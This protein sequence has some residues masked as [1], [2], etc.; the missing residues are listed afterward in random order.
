MISFAGL[1]ALVFVGLFAYLVYLVH[2]AV[3]L[4]RHL[5]YSDYNTYK[6]AV[7]SSKKVY[8][9]NRDSKIES[10]HSVKGDRTKMTIKK[11]SGISKTD[12]A[13]VDLAHADPESVMNSIDEYGRPR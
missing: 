13:L 3:D 10:I 2:E 8:K 4:Y 7:R 1:V 11:P 5:S 9:P 6:E 12:D